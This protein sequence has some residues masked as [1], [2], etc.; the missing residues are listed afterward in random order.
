MGIVLIKKIYIHMFYSFLLK[1]EPIG[2]SD[3]FDVE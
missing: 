1:I 2:F 3:E